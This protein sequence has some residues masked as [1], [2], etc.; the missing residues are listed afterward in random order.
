MIDHRDSCFG[1]RSIPALTSAE[2]VPGFRK[3]YVLLSRLTF[4]LLLGC[5]QHLMDFVDDPFPNS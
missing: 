2:P 4:F 1:A 5:A 3:L